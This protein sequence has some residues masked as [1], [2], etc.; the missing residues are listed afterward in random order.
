MKNKKK[1]NSS[2][3]NKKYSL[4]SVGTILL[5]IAIFA[6]VQFVFMDDIFYWYARH[7]MAE[8]AKEIEEI[9][10]AKKG[11]GKIIADIEG[12]KNFY[13][14]IYKPR[15]TLVYT[16][17]SNQAIYD[18]NKN[19]V[20]N[21]DE[22]KPRIMKILQ[23]LEYDE[24]YY[25]ELRQEYYATAQYLVYG[26]FF[27]DDMSLEI[28]YPVEIIESNAQIASEVTFYL[29]LLIMFMLITT[30]IRIGLMVFAPL[31]N[32]IIQTKKM[33]N[34]DF[35]AKCPPYK[36]SDLNELSASINSLSRSLSIAM[37]KLQSENRQLE[38]DILYQRKLEKSRRSFISNVS[39]ELKTPIA[40]IKGYAEGMKM[41]VGCDSV[42]EF[43]DIIIDES[44]KMNDLI[45]R[46][47]EYMKLNSGAYKIF[48]S[49]FN[50]AEVLSECAEGLSSK[51]EEKNIQYIA[52]INLDFTAF[53]D[54]LM[55]Q[56]IFT[57]YL[58]NAISHIDYD[59]IIRVTAT[60]VGTAYRVRVFNTGKP[61]PGTDIENIWQSFYRADKSHSREEGRFGLGLSF[62]ATIQEMTGEKYGVENKKDGVEFWFDVKKKV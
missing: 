61:I 28:Y 55:V 17:S 29:C 35:T 26:Y 20:V 59:R 21:I 37:E 43:C 3:L 22:L 39:H 62:V 10:F 38:T 27:N 48:S 40:I 18:D 54:S 7:N 47:M 9:D 60:D 50:L 5:C 16:T 23:R 11:F 53:S 32:M 44:D 6:L 58:S 4:I 8:A 49:E 51:I 25:Y 19:N 30:S 2:E 56:N 36:I 46:L 41:G 12:N 42:E 1:R 34:M 15:D 24:D 13:I 31:K 57:N 14:E 45:I 33:A 52:D